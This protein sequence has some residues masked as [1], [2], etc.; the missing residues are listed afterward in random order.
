MISRWPLF[1]QTA[2]R[3][4]SR[5]LDHL[6]GAGEQV[7]RHVEAE[8]LGGLEV[9]DKLEFGRLL[10]RDVAW[11]RPAQNF[12]DQ[13]G[14]APEQI[15]GSLPVPPVLP[16]ERIAQHCCAAGEAQ[17]DRP[18]LSC[19]GEIQRVPIDG[20]L[21]RANETPE[22]D[23]DSVDPDVAAHDDVH[24]PSHVLT[25]TAANAFAEDRGEYLC[26]RQLAA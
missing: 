18:G 7:W 1:D 25:G 13:L 24:N 19:R 6:V 22:V 4:R 26:R 11:L 2:T 16:G 20:D 10:D 17:G 8:R 21:A 15:R 14:G 5:S 3:A 12:V 9:D 23:D